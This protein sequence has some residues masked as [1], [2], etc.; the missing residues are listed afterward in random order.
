MLLKITR[1]CA[2]RCT[3]CLEEATPDGEHMSMEVFQDALEFIKKMKPLLLIVTGGEPTDHPQFFEIMQ[4]L[5]EI[6]PKDHLLIASNGLFLYNEEITERVL[7][8]GVNVQVT[9]DVRYYPLTINTQRQHPLLNYVDHIESMFPQGRAVKNGY[10]AFKSNAPKCFNLRSIACSPNTISIRDA[11][12]YL[13]ISGK[14]CTPAIG[15]HGEILLGESSLCGNIGKV[16]DSD[17]SLLQNIRT[18]QC[19]RCKM[20]DNLPPMY[21]KAIHKVQGF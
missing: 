12:K 2:M 8:L 20:E 4:A 21:K 5:L 10:Q 7:S 14:F 6:V 9:N 3:H 16:T 1:R 19:N 11:I 15:I 18:F 13:E 17:S